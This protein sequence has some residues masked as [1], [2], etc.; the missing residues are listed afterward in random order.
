V[1]PV[2]ILLLTNRE[3]DMPVAISFVAAAVLAVAA[4]WLA[5]WLRDG[6]VGFR[7]RHRWCRAA[8]LARSAVRA[9][10]DLAG[11]PAG[12]ALGVAVPQAPPSQA[13]GGANAF[14]HGACCDQH[15]EFLERRL[16]LLGVQSRWEPTKLGGVVLRVQ[17]A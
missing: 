6:A 7:C 3:D 9:A 1:T 5:G 8:T 12:T 10:R 16:Y 11:R 4:I 13:A 2:S 15:W 17:R 14:Q